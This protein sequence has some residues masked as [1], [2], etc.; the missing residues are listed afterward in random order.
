[1][2]Q[3]N[4]AAKM[5]LSMANYTNDVGYISVIFEKLETE[6]EFMR[7]IKFVKAFQKDVEGN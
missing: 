2:R 1:M 7:T 3:T 4:S 6:D 5:L